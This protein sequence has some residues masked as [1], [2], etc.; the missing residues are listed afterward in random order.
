MYLSSYL[1]DK[2]FKLM[3]G[4]D[5]SKFPSQFRLPRLNSLML[6]TI[7]NLNDTMCLAFSTDYFSAISD[8]SAS[9]SA[10]FVDDFILGIFKLL[11]A[12]T[13]SSIASELSI[14]A[15]ST[16]VCEIKDDNSELFNL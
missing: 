4:S 8:S 16:V 5:K 12:V 9:S 1:S 11:L 14:L 10:T 3:Q 13:I 15:I 7:D 2:A 6:S